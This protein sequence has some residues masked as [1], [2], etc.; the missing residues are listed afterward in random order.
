MKGKIVYVDT[1]IPS[2]YR[3]N[4]G[5]HIYFMEGAKFEGRN[6]AGQSIYNDEYIVKQFWYDGQNRIILIDAPEREEEVK[7]PE[8]LQETVLDEGEGYTSFNKIP[9][10]IC[11]GEQEQPDEVPVM[12]GDDSAKDDGICVL[13]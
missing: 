7:R 10:S 1:E 8:P 5:E 4:P 13:L 9:G 6:V 3:I 12:G 11:L 2:D